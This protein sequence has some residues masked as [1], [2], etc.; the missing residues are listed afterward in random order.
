[1]DASKLV[2]PISKERLV[3]DLQALGVR[4]GDLLN[5]KASMRSM[6]YVIGGPRTLIEALCEVIG[7]E[8]TIVAEAFVN[9]YPLPLRNLNRFFSY[10]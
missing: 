4:P 3:H 5:V 7:P 1:M 9:V 2:K 10:S 8:G 6:G